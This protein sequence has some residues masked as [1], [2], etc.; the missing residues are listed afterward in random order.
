MRVAG[1]LKTEGDVQ[2]DGVIDGDIESTNLTIG[3][4]AVVNGE[5]VA[6]SVRVWGKVNGRVRSKDVS[7]LE[8]AEVRGDILHDTLEVQKGAYIEGTVKRQDAASQDDLKPTKVSLVQSGGSGSSGSAG[9]ET[10]KQEDKPA[11]N[12][13]S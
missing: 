8:T 1:D 2:I 3:K 11:E 10:K 4:T 12:T 6:D 13:G 7:L 9:D 5:V